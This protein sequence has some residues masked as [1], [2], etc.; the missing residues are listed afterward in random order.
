[1]T[2]FNLEKD[3]AKVKFILEK[4]SLPKITAEV[5]AILDV[6]G[7]TKAYYLGGVIQEA[8]QRIVPVA[9]N[10]DD[11]GSLPVYVFA[12]G[13]HYTR[14]AAEL[15]S[16]NY[17]DFVRE[18][19]LRQEGLLELWGGTAYAPV[20]RSALTD[21]G[22]LTTAAP[23]VGLFKRLLGKPPAGAVFQE[24]SRSGIPALVYFLTDGENEHDDREP[25]R[26]LLTAAAAARSNVYFNFIGV[27]TANFGFLQEI[28]DAYPNTGF[29]QIK[30]IERTAG[31]DEIYEYLIPSEL[32]TW[33]HAGALQG[34]QR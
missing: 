7:S 20:L 14:L 30:D 10:F 2:T 15:R 29:A 26:K 34:V 22:F 21:L 31:S 28:G 8:L 5:V 11:N 3:T 33:L 27:G 6:S 12:D 24:Q 9:L 1:M 13:D 16:A 19:I 32:T 23:V 17:A 25:T 18:E 4:R